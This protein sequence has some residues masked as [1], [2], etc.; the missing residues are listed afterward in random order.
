M[1]GD[2]SHASPPKQPEPTKV[3]MNDTRIMDRWDHSS[4]APENR[5]CTPF[6][7]MQGHQPAE[8][9]RYPSAAP[10]LRSNGLAQLRTSRRGSITDGSTTKTHQPR[11]KGQQQPRLG[12]S[13][14]A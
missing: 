12:V 10:H 11:P 4:S 8:Y 2:N 6:E 9:Q 13:T 3:P 7:Q 5:M 14:K 1:L